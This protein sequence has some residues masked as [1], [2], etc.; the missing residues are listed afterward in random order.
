MISRNDITFTQCANGNR[1]RSLFTML[2]VICTTRMTAFGGIL[3]SF[4]NHL[5]WKGPDRDT[6]VTRNSLTHPKILSTISLSREDCKTDGENMGLLRIICPAGQYWSTGS[7]KLCPA[8][9]YSALPGESDC[10][11]CPAGAYSS[12]GSASCITC[13][14]GS[15]SNMSSSSCTLCSVG[16]YSTTGV[17]CEKCVPGSYSDISGSSVCKLCPV[18]SFSGS[19]ASSCTPCSSA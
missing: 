11:Q 2:I 4:M 17:H 15:Y 9:L 8:G 5:D 13:L 10:A 18:G 3:N 12:A 16:Y 14:P 6:D 19:G 7:C 1:Y